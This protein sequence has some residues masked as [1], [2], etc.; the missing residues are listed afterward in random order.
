MSFSI[1]SITKSRRDCYLGFELS[2]EDVVLLLYLCLQGQSI[3][4]LPDQA[5]QL[6]LQLLHLWQTKLLFRTD[7]QC[8]HLT[9]Q[10]EAT[11][12]SENMENT[13]G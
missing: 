5:C 10:M 8:L 11:V 2:G 9:L 6:A 3:S 7:E 13:K 4:L 12:L 1:V